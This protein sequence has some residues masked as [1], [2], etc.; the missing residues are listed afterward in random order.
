MIMGKI[1]LIVEDSRDFRGVLRF[2]LEEDGHTVL[3]AENGQAAVDIAKN[4]L[5][6]LILMDIAMPIMDGL[7][8]AKTIRKLDGAARLPII[9]IT[10]YWSFYY[11]KAKDVGFDDLINKPVEPM[12]LIPYINRYLGN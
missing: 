9:A 6:D 2:L 4:Q 8:A 11:S 10:A 1:I 5:P 12:A 3:E 7:E